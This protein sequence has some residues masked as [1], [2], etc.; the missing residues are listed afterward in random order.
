MQFL[1]LAT[2]S[3]HFHPDEHFAILFKLV[4]AVKL[5][6]PLLLYLNPVGI[7]H[8]ILVLRLGQEVSSCRNPMSVGS[9]HEGNHDVR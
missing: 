1:K 7:T 2:V 5:V 8:Q 9:S 4:D 3:Q 6:A